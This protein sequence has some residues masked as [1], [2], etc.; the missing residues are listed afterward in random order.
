MKYKAKGATFLLPPNGPKIKKYPSF[1]T[2]EMQ[3]DDMDEV[4][5]SWKISQK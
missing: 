1:A 2:N 3:F 5:F 4:K